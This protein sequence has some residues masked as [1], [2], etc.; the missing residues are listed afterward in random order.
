MNAYRDYFRACHV[1]YTTYLRW[2]TANKA[3]REY[4]LHVE[5][6]N[7]EISRAFLNVARRRISA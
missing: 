2:T 6:K 5:K 3:I 7:L 1:T 4:H